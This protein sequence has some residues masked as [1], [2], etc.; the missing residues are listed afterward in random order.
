M[1]LSASEWKRMVGTGAYLIHYNNGDPF[2][3]EQRMVDQFGGEV[4]PYMDRLFEASMDYYEKLATD[5]LEKLPAVE[6]YKK[7]WGEG[8]EK[9]PW[10]QF[11]EKRTK[12]SLEKV[13]GPGDTKQL[14]NF[15]AITSANTQ[16]GVNAQMGVRAFTQWKA[17]H[18]FENVTR[19]DA[20]TQYAETGKWSGIKT[21]D[22][23]AA[24]LGDDN[25][26]VVD[27]W[28]MRFF[29]YDRNPRND[30]E[31]AFFAQAMR[32][33]AQELGLA[34][35]QLQAVIWTLVRVGETG[36]TGK[37]LGEMVLE[38]IRRQIAQ[39][40]LTPEMLGMSGEKLKGFGIEPP[41]QQMFLGEEMKPG[42][43]EKTSSVKKAFTPYLQ[44]AFGWE[45]TITEE[46]V[47]LWWKKSELTEKGRRVDHIA[48]SEVL[49][50]G[51]YEVLSYSYY[52]PLEVSFGSDMEEQPELFGVTRKPFRT[53]EESEVY[54]DK[55]MSEDW[56]KTSALV[57][58]LADISGHA[59]ERLMGRLTDVDINSISDRAEYFADTHPTGSWAVLVYR[60]D[61]FMCDPTLSNG[62]SVV[63]IIRDGR[64]VTLMYRRST[65]P[66]TPEALRV[67]DVAV[68]TTSSLKEASISE[69]LYESGAWK[70]W[71]SDI[72]KFDK[73]YPS[74]VAVPKYEAGFLLC[75]PSCKE[76]KKHLLDF[77]SVSTVG[78]GVKI[79]EGWLENHVKSCPRCSEYTEKNTP[80]PEETHPRYGPRRPLGQEA[81]LDIEFNRKDTIDIEGNEM[82]EEFEAWW[83]SKDGGYDLTVDPDEMDMI[84]DVAMRAWAEGAKRASVDD[85]PA[86]LY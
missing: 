5:V 74:D 23:A 19:A 80:K 2:V 36:D 13:F 9:Y 17:G 18:P 50:G 68:Y 12:D 61:A 73:Q 42:Y 79:Q 26:V 83:Y 65:Q 47:N 58:K 66:F 84:K 49:S 15:L 3:W 44:T 29:G 43:D 35:A 10:S 75:D 48:W 76:W 11:W 51:S 8:V 28:V 34:P 46:G 7:M 14:I 40:R 37:P 63:A 54:I 60:C 86:G 39:G 33:A 78:E 32:S 25:A 6:T 56:S 27:I 4:T 57:E 82:N 21:N 70:D 62:D 55:L 31:Y 53:A 38:A 67:D 72:A 52:E 16:L 71:P 77:Q 20:L 41:A 64:V 81:G 69:D 30:A 24:M 85:S 22:F 45:H 59:T 1:G